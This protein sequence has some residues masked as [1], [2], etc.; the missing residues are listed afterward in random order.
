MSLP[1][2]GGGR[3]CLRQHLVD[4]TGGAFGHPPE[5]TPWGSACRERRQCPPGDGEG[6]H[7]VYGELLG[8]WSREIKALAEE[9]V[10]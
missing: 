6:N 3:N 10:I 7:Y 2:R 1:L 9:D 4:E 5:G 8:M